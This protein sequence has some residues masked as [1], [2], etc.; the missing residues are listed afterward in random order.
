VPLATLVAPIER[1]YLYPDQSIATALRSL[2]GRSYIPVV[3]RANRH[4]LEGVLA[5]DDV[6]RG[7]VARPPSE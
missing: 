4:R 6:V 3:H 1:P 5:L 2:R 7:M